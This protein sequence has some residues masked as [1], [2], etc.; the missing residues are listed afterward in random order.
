MRDIRVRVEFEVAS[1]SPPLALEFHMEQYVASCASDSLHDRH[2]CSSGWPVDV[3]GS[4]WPGLVC[5][6]NASQ[7]TN[8]A[9]INTV[10]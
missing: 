2:G 6:L 9:S 4:A 7:D 5:N 1:G 3:T 8:P 10:W